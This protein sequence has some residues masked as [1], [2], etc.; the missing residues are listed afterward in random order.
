MSN[1]FAAIEALRGRQQ[2]EEQRAEPGALSRPG[3]E[4]LRGLCRLLPLPWA[5]TTI[6]IAFTEGRGAHPGARPRSDLD[7]FV[8]CDYTAKARRVD[9]ARRSRRALPRRPREQRQPLRRGLGEV[10]YHSPTATKGAGDSTTTSSSA[11]GLIAAR[12]S[13]QQRAPRARRAGPVHAA[14]FRSRHGR[15][16]RSRCRRRRRS[17]SGPRGSS[18]AHAIRA[19]RPLHLGALAASTDAS[20]RA[21]P[22][23]RATR[24]P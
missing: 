24:R 7:L 15:C 20:R 23:P 18:A 2:V 3:H 9:Q 10:P 22:P 11:A 16:P 5:K 14:I 19:A 1:T 17:R 6:P 8:A 21:G 13:G 4:R 12:V